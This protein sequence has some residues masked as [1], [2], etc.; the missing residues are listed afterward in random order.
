MDIVTFLG[1]LSCLFGLYTSV[2][3]I[4]QESNIVFFGSVSSTFIAF[5]LMVTSLVKGSIIIGILVG[6]NFSFGILSLYI[7][8]LKA[9]QARERGTT[10]S[11]PPCN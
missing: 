1:I 6:V 2:G 3:N 8:F 5:V 10:T 4:I 7:S 9:R 11:P